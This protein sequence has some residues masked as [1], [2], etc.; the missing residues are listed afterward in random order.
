MIDRLKVWLVSQNWF[1]KTR[2]RFEKTK[3]FLERIKY[4]RDTSF[5]RA[6]SN[7]KI[8]GSL[9][10]VSI[11]SL[12][13][14]ILVLGAIL[15][16][17]TKIRD[18]TTWL[19]PLSEEEKKFA[20]EQL[21]IYA[22]LLTAIFSI[23]FATIGIILSGG[24]TRLRRDI[25]YLLVS[26]QVGSV[27][28]RVLVLAA[29]FCLTA[30]SLPIFGF[31]PGLLNYALGT[32]LTL[33]T[34]LA[35]FPLGKR[36]FNF[37][38]LIHLAKIGILP[39]ITRHIEGAANPKNSP[40][41]SNHHS[42]SA[43]QALEQLAYIDDRLKTGVEGLSDTLPELNDAYSYL[44]MH[45]LHQKHKISYES[46]WFPRK[47]AHKQWFFAG[48]AATSMALQTSSQLIV[49]EKADLQWFENEVVDRIMNHIKL[50]FGQGDFKLALNLINRFS[51]RSPTYAKHF[52]FD[53][54]I[55][56]IKDIKDIIEEAF[57][58]PKGAEIDNITRILIADTW[59]ALG[60]NL[61]LEALRR[62]MTFEKDLERFFKADVWTDKELR[63]LPTFLQVDLAFI[64]KW[65]DFEIKIE[66]QRQSKQKY[67]Q[68]LAVQKLLQKYANIV[69]EIC[70]FQT[71]IVPGFA[72][73]LSNMK[74]TEAATQIV[75]ASL[76]SYWKLPRWFNELSQL[77]ER[78][79]AYLHYSEEYYKFPQIPTAKMA[80]KLLEARD[81]S[82]LKLG[83]ADFIKHVFENEQSEDLPDHFGQIYFELAEACIEA[84]QQN[85]NGK[86]DNVFPMFFAL[87]LLASDS[88]FV[89]PNLD[90]NSE[91][92]L[93]LIS[94]VIN[95][96]ASV[97]GFAILYG[98]YFD[99]AELS[100]SAL[101]KFTSWTQ[102]ASDKQIYLK[103]MLRLSDPNNFSMAAS[104][105]GM[106][107]FNWKMA[108][109][110]I[111]RTEGYGDQMSYR[112]S[113]PHKDKIVNAFL[114][115]HSDAS[116]LFFATQILPIIESVDFEID[117]HITII[118]EYLKDED[119]QVSP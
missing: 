70:E 66:G 117:H 36:L 87:A 119:T 48:D 85:A 24:Y 102:K 49:D 25:I 51:A 82:I 45:Y 50:A 79:N 75:L 5:S 53:I 41:L 112:R 81:A 61:C 11:K 38:D 60:N 7:T 44:M 114:K 94:T 19:H 118:S 98:A 106:I 92:R 113:H 76:H 83:N 95:D 77:F 109:E 72:S 65:I 68:Q 101:D 58:S 90:I 80:E 32:F 23:Y 47:G 116:H 21:R 69:P 28:S 57:A 31:E 111:A 93:H 46:Y 73:S 105:R 104:P 9:A 100:K 88:K 54:G 12:I 56:E 33:A 43:R 52:H 2:T 10:S 115:S 78:Y 18:H 4:R 14:V 16:L 3:F 91:F 27:Y 108:F 22:Q 62:I 30:T 15:F 13:C 103:R 63:G 71:V 107:R 6:G 34:S 96:L 26:E 29:T 110:Q 1:W 42:K 74:H 39:S 86:F 55:K 35:L 97:L 17:E 8:L 84:L 59:A 64:V 40:S 20:I 89:D 67:I 99:N 37:F